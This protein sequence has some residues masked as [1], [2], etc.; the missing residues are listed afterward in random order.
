MKTGEDG[1]GDGFPGG[2]VTRRAYLGALGAGGLLGS[3]AGCT[4]PNDIVDSPA[5]FGYQFPYDAETTHIGPWSTSDPSA[6]YPICYETESYTTPGL[7]TQLGDVVESITVDGATATISYAEDFSWWS[8]D[9]VTAR[10]PWIQ[11]RI[12]SFV[13]TG[14][15]PAVSLVDEY[16]LQYEFDRP[17]DRTLAVS[18]VTDGM[19]RTRANFYEPW[20]GRL[21]DASTD[22]ERREI[23]TDLR[24]D[25]P[26]LQTIA[27]EGLGCGPYELVEVSINRLMFERY[28]DHPRADALSIPRLWFP[29]VQQESIEN[30]I[31]KGWLDGGTG[32]LR[33]QRGAPPENLEQLASYRTNSGT[34]LVLD[35]RNKHLS[36]TGVRRALL[37]LLP[38]D[39]IVEVTNW[40]EPKIRQTGLAAPA[41]HRWLS[42][43][44]REAL[45]EY[46]IGADL[47]QAT[48]YMEAAGYTRTGQDDWQGPD[49]ASARVRIGTPVWD[50]YVSA[51]SVVASSLDEFGFDVTT[52]RIP[53]T[54][55]HYEVTNH[56]HDLMLWPF[57]GKPF[58]AYNVTSDAAAS[59]GY[60]VTDPATER[61]SQG[62]PIDVRVPGTPGAIDASESERRDVNLVETWRTIEGP[63]DRQTTE[64]AIETF[65]TWWN[66][67]LPD[68]YLG[69]AVTGLWGNTRDFSWPTYESSSRY[70]TAGS[71]GNPIFHMLK[72][73]S[74]ESATDE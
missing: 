71:N 52:D 47:E 7:D 31:S 14:S 30:L 36:R 67:A 1:R 62:K 33:N 24:N 59:I 38:L 45:H 40:G 32:H 6:F 27:D 13:S 16:T 18:R 55:I 29:V 9:P 39:D 73:G 19:I 41:E 23:I 48:A 57:D 22:R 65:A 51:S 61:S 5:V 10:D 17:L 50:E 63:S 8:G 58:T 11:E 37:S 20:L 12:Q 3:L 46:P 44:V 60:G 70:G 49:G 26:G 34:K 64:A 54:K 28:D 15:R 4:E 43:S 25:S 21:E 74:V 69:A 56:T 53:N 2:G 35:W 72:Q 66:D 68:L 42:A